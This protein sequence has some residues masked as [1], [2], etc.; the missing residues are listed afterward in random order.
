MCPFKANP[1]IF[2]TKLD[3]RGECLPYIL[4]RF[5]GWWLIVRP[6]PSLELLWWNPNLF[7]VGFWKFPWYWNTK[8]E[9]DA[10]SY[11]MRDPQDRLWWFPY[12]VTNFVSSL[13]TAFMCNRPELRCG[14]VKSFYPLWAF[15]CAWWNSLTLGII[16]WNAHFGENLA[17]LFSSF[18]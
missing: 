4:V 17:C 2:E 14:E 16:L 8:P 5:I 3:L 10:V 11:I 9:M 12:L 1:Y 13:C 7:R 15:L 6:L 18:L